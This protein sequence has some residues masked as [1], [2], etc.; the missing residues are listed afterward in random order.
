LLADC[1]QEDTAQRLIARMACPGKFHGVQGIQ[2]RV[3]PIMLHGK[4]LPNQHYPDLP[5]DLGRMTRQGSQ[6]RIKFP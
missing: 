4:D 5:E 2:L 3:L 6:A 1:V